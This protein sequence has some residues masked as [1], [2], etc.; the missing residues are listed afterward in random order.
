VPIRKQRWRK[1]CINK[2]KI[3]FVKYCNSIYV[4]IAPVC[5]MKKVLGSLHIG[6]TSK[7]II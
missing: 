3:I 6:D 2:G 5:K 1:T 7:K 4:N